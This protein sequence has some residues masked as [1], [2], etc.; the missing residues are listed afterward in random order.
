VIGQ[1]ESYARDE[2]CT[3]LHTYGRKRWLGVFDGY[4]EKQIITDKELS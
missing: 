1:L 3:R 4:Q 2:G